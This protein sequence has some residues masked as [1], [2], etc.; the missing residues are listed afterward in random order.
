M[1]KIV[2]SLRVVELSAFDFESRI[3]FKGCLPHLRA[4]ILSFTITVSPNEKRLCV[5]SL[6]GDVVGDSFF[7]LKSMSKIKHKDFVDLS[8]EATSSTTG[9]SK[10]CPGRHDFHWRYC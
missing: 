1:N 7:I 10:S 5:T 8:T 2:R 6:L 9:A 3:A 4:N